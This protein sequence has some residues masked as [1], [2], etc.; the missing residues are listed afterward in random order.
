MKLKNTHNI[1]NKMIESITIFS[2][3]IY[4]KNKAFSKAHV[5]LYMFLLRVEDR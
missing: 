5:A 2:T 1:I 4:N 3:I